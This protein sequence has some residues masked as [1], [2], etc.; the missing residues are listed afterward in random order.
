MKKSVLA[1]ILVLASVFASAQSRHTRIL[2]QVTL[3]K[4]T[5]SITTTTLYMPKQDG[6]NV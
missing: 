5:A 1:F 4:Q 3:L 6:L 2:A